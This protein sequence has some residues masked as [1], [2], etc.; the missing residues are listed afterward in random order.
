MPDKADA[1]PDNLSGGQQQRVGTKGL[2]IS[3][4]SSPDD[5]AVLKSI[6]ERFQV[7]LPEFPENGVDSGTYMDN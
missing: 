3:F 4:V 1:Y 7:E 5:E 6:E 2:S